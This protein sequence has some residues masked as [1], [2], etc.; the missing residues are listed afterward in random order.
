[1]LDCL[2]AGLTSNEIGKVMKI[3]THTVDWYVNG[4]QD[5][6]EARNRHHLVA[7]AFRLGMIG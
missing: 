6:F 4:L 3:S 2:A 1:M 5:K 7:L